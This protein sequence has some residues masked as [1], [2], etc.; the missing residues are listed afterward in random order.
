[1][2]SCLLAIALLTFISAPTANAFDE[3]E[4]RV[5][6]STLGQ[7]TNVELAIQPNPPLPSPDG[8]VAP[9][10]LPIP[11]PLDD[12]AP[13]PPSGKPYRRIFKSHGLGM[14][15]IDR[16]GTVALEMNHQPYV[17]GLRL[18]PTNVDFTYWNQIHG[19]GHPHIDQWA[20]GTRPDFCGQYAVWYRL[21]NR[22]HYH[23][24]AGRI[25]AH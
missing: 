7:A 21:N 25:K 24:Q 8:G 5:A 10:T 16:Q 23:G 4:S 1:M 9:K 22:W 17:A 11:A 12:P 20:V 2:R 18:G 19:T 6:A 13:A 14:H 3:Q 15:L